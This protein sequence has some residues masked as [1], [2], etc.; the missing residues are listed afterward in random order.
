MDATKKM[1]NEEA[2]AKMK[3][4]VVLLNFARDLLADEEAVAKALVSGKM[5]KYVSDFPTPLSANMENAIVIPH[6]GAST[7][8][9]EDNC[10]VMAAKELKDFLENGNISHSVNYPD[11]NM[12]VCKSAGRVIIFHKNVPNMIAQ[13]SSA[14]AADNINISDMLNKSRGEWAYT[15]VDVETPATKQLVAD[16]EAIKGCVKVS[17]IK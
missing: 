10:A 12:G 15:M 13:F 9:S 7:E 2:I 17:V 4:G 3:D 14:F 5:K 11:C 16:I 6:L 8:E 1:I